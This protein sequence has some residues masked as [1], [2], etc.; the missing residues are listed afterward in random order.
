MWLSATLALVRESAVTRMRDAVA[1]DLHDTIAQSL[2]GAA[3]RLEGLRNWIAGGGDPE[4]EI[5]SIKSALKGEQVQVRALIDRLRRGENV[6]PDRAAQATIGPL[7]SDLSSYWGMEAGLSAGSGKILIPG[8]LAH[9][10][11]Q[12]VRE[13]VA[14]AVRHGEAETVTVGFAERE[15]AL[16]VTV[17]DNGSGIDRT[18]EGR[19]PRSISERIAQLG[20]GL[21]VESDGSGTTLRVWLPLEASR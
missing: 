5:Q 13:G 1:R 12:L 14:N 11:R 19:Q 20:G 10:L 9:E 21:T 16:H 15:G 4:E 6:L 18:L 8:W 3:M 2:A 17:A 7:L